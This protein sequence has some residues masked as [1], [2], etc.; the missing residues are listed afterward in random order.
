MASIT[1]I[2]MKNVQSTGKIRAIVTITLDNEIAIHD[3]RIIY[4]NDKMF[5]AMP[6]KKDD[7]NGE[8]R[9]IVHPIS[10]AARNKLEEHILD[11]YQRLINTID[12]ST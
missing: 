5:I 6:Y 9:D 10:V 11:E 3:I 4:A 1:D 2:R 7:I 12:D 8:Y